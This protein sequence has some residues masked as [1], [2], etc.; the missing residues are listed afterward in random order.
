MIRARA[1]DDRVPDDGAIRGVGAGGVGPL[2]GDVDEELFGVPGD[3]GGEVCVEGEFDGGV[4]FLFGGVVVD[5]AFC[6]VL[7]ELGI[8]AL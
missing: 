5:A 4:F 8:F 6:S 2:G 1:R 7:K 3:E